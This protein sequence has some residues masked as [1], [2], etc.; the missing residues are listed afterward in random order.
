V[1]ILY[2][3]IL[4]VTTGALLGLVAFFYG[5]CRRLD[6]GLNWGFALN[7]LLTLEIGFVQ[8][9]AL[10]SMPK[11][12]FRGLSR[13]NIFFNFLWAS[14]CALAASTTVFYLIMTKAWTLTL[15]LDWLLYPSVVAAW[16]LVTMASHLW[17]PSV[18]LPRRKD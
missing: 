3:S 2:L 9:F 5:V 15:P 16:M 17:M 8:V 4:A 11:L 14:S 6:W 12:G 18:S 13:G 1:K 7:L 10:R